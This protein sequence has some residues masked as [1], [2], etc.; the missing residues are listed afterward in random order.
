MQEAHKY[1]T[2]VLDGQG[3]DEMM[4]GYLPYYFVYLNQLWKMGKYLSFFKEVSS[5]WDVVMRFVKKKI[6]VETQNFASL[7]NNNLQ[8]NMQGNYFR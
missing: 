3:A 6:F 2:V 7:L 4:A 8:T 5:S 1:V